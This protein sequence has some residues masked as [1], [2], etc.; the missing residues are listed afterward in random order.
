M[1][2]TPDDFEIRSLNEPQSLIAH[3]DVDHS[4]QLYHFKGFDDDSG[5]GLVSHADSVSKF[6]HER[7]GHLNYGYLQELHAHN[8]V[9]SL[10]K[11]SCSDG[12]YPGCA[13]G[14]QHQ[15]PFPKGNA[16][17]A[18]SL[19]ELVHSDLMVFPHP[20]FT[21]ARYALTF[22]DDFLRRTWV[23]FLKYKSDV[24]AHFKV[25]KALV[26]N[27]S[28]SCIKKLCTD[29]GGEYFSIEFSKF[30]QKHGIIHQ[31]SVPHTP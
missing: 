22:I 26:E 12:V 8:M 27:Q 4:L 9:T 14:K 16:N 1:L 2:F 3:G 24:F 20:S 29:N 18:S 19:L 7:F 5:T 23:Y 21:G 6:W 15:D 11:V 25:F 13:L 10:P 31:H 30:L 28:S 17:R